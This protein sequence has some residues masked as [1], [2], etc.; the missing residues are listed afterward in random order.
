ML[1]LVEASRMADLTE[2]LLGEVVKLARAGA[3]F[4]LLAAN[5][6][7]IVFKPLRGRSPIPM[8]SIVEVTCEAVKAFGLKRVGLFGTRFTMQA[9]FYPEG[10][11]G[12]GA[13]LVLPSAE[14]QDYIHDKYLGELVKGIIRSETREAL[15]AIVARLRAQEG[16]DG[17]ILGGTELPL[18]LREADAGSLPFLDTTRLHV[19][20]VVAEMLS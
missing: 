1:D 15:L 3:N 2:Y 20:R 5:T 19:E 17:L 16:I 12:A 8:I 4:A 9:P 7:H 10:L 14:E 11:A 13:R 6:P 18:I